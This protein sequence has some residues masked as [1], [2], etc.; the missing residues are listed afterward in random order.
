MDFDGDTIAV[1]LVD[2]EVAEDTY[3][4]MSPRYINLYHKTN[5]PIYKPSLETLNGLSE[6]SEVRPDQPEDL[7]DPKEYYDSWKDLVMDAEV[8]KTLPVKKPIMFTGKIGSE[9]YDHK[10]TTYGR[11]KISK[12]I[13]ADLDNI[14]IDEPLKAI[15]GNSG[16]KLY[17]YLNGHPNGPEK[18]KELQRIALQ[19]VTKAGVVTFNFR[20]LTVNTNTDSYKKLRAIVDDP[21]LTDQDKL[22][23]VTD[24]YDKYCKEVQDQFDEDLKKEL[25]RAGKVKLTSLGDMNTPQLII[26]GVDEKVTIN[27]GSLLAG[28]DEKEYQTHAVENRSLQSLKVMGVPSSGV[29]IEKDAERPP[30]L[31]NYTKCWNL[32]HNNQQ[33]YEFKEYHRRNG[34]RDGANNSGD[35]ISE[36]AKENIRTPWYLKEEVKL[37]D[38]RYNPSW[39]RE[40]I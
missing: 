32:K 35:R 12:V 39:K 19:E 38:Y 28:L 8:H 20:N 7:D 23:R 2:P 37:N 36:G 13:D 11:L 1:Y 3:K 4:K 27:H 31:K 5:L 18:I 34:R 15:N 25:K 16:A 26:S 17:Q 9:E 29:T 33:L 30:E 40:M 21:N 22:L 10:I 14:H 24:L 6:L